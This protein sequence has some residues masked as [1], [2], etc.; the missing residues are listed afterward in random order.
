[1]KILEKLKKRKNDSIFE[2]ESKE[3]IQLPEIIYRYESIQL[4]LLTKN[5]SLIVVFSIQLFIHGIIANGLIQSNFFNIANRRK[6]PHL[7]DNSILLK[8][9]LISQIMFI[10]NSFR[11]YINAIR[12]CYKDSKNIKYLIQDIVKTITQ[13]NGASNQI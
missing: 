12:K 5:Q 8:F 7:S 9:I 4:K 10:I 3:D 13:E 1:M 11:N 2:K 6:D